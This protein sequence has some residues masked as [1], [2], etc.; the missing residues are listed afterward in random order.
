[1]VDLGPIEKVRS[2]FVGLKPARAVLLALALLATS[3][4]EAA[5]G[6]PSPFSD[7]I[8]PAFAG[9][10]DPRWRA[11]MFKKWQGVKE[12][13][14][15]QIEGPP[16]SCRPVPGP[17]IGSCILPEW[18]RFVEALKQANA[19]KK[20]NATNLEINRRTYVTDLVN[21]KQPDFW[22]TPIEFFS[23]NGDC[24]DFAIS[25]FFTLL[26]AGLSNDLMK[27]VIVDDL[28]LKIPHAVFAIDTQDGI[29][30]L[31]NQIKTV[32]PADR[33]FH[34]R[35]IYALDMT[36]AWVFR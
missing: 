29:M 13:N 25:K 4:P 5:A 1:M 20:L 35:A 7:Q 14:G 12:R 31:D 36:G 19:T 30:I 16:P 17:G 3:G 24:E 28:N 2:R 18:A 11:D 26:Y 6:L 23:R 22:A 33:I 27:I 9:A 34:Y 8:K 10:A 15:R 32:M 21:W